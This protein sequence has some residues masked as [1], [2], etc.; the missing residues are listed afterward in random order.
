MR[1]KD[2]VAIVTGGA[3]GLGRVYAQR[4]LTEGARVVIGDIVNPAQTTKELASHGEILGVHMDV[5][6][7]ASVNDMVE[8]AVGRFGRI[9]VLVN[10]AGIAASLR[11]TPFDEI[12][13]ADWD[14]VIAVNLK[15][16]WL[17]TKAVAPHMKRAGGG[18]VINISSAMVHKGSPFSAH[19]VAS[20]GAVM[21]L[22]RALARE[23]GAF[24][25]TVNAIAPGLVLS[26]T[27][28]ANPNTATLTPT[29]IQGR[30]LKRDQMPEDLE[31]TL[32]FLAS[33]ASDF[34]TGQ[35]LVVDGGSVFA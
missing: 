15:S 21:A 34:M 24:N 27:M 12:A 35:T 5:T 3:V 19:Y 6:A 17:C 18:K 23:L 28:Q 33:S 13:E 2:K 20:K 8:Q 7:A 11:P 29:V 4:F 1:L 16:V 22:T 31:G 30:S 26:D 10:N 9:D 25:V 32:L 14:R